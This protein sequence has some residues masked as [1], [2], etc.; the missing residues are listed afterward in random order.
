MANILWTIFL[1]ANFLNEKS[2]QIMYRY[3][4]LQVQLTLTPLPPV[5]HIHV[6]VE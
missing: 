6:C 1:N 2:I 3:V 5:P 4:F